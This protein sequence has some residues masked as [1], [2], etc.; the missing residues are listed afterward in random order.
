MGDRLAY[1]ADYELREF[2]TVPKIAGP[3][4]ERT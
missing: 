4:M 3:R 1:H 2:S